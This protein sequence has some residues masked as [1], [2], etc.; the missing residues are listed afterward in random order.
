MAVMS[1]VE[2]ARL[3]GSQ[4]LE[5]FAEI[6]AVYHEAFPEY[7]LGDHRA[8]TTRQAQSAGFVAITA[9]DQG[10]LVGFAYGL[11]LA[12]TTGWWRGLDPAGPDGFQVETGS[13]T[14]AVIDLAVLPSH[15]G[16]G[17]G[18]RLMDEL[19]ASRPEERATLATAPHEV[20]NQRMYERWG[21]HKVG[22]KPGEPGTTEPVFEL[23]VIALR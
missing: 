13:R 3:D 6:Q 23:Y 15:R 14:L 1:D 10:A 4:A 12:A 2:L 5:V 8:R 22:R 20:E 11:P 9:R 17:L 7:D 19:L 16:Q 21:W 18:R